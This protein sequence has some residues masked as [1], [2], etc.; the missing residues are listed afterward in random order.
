MSS[1]LPPT[2]A[3]YQPIQQEPL[4]GEPIELDD[5]D[6]EDTASVLDRH[7]LRPSVNDRIRG[8]F[9]VFGAAYLLP[10][11]GTFL[12]ALCLHREVEPSAQQ[13]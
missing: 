3:G 13:W 4:E 9:F 10:W 11:N 8:I 2:E 12:N 7:L 6:H 1:F 5:S